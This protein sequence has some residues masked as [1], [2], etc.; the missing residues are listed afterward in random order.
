[1]SLSYQHYFGG[2]R[3]Q[4]LL[5]TIILSGCSPA[6]NHENGRVPGGTNQQE[7]INEAGPTNSSNVMPGIG[8]PGTGGKDTQ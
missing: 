5:G 7:A 3:L 4:L 2:S 1:M 8:A 6:A